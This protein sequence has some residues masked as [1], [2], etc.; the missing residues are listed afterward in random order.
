MNED[1]RMFAAT[2]RGSRRSLSK[3]RSVLRHIA[4]TVLATALVSAASSYAAAADTE[5]QQRVSQLKAP[6]ADEIVFTAVGDMGLKQPLSKSTDPSLQSLFDLLRASDI[7]FMNLEGVMTDKGFPDHK[8][9]SRAHPSIVEDYKWAGTDLVSLGNNHQ[10]DYFETGMERTIATLDAAGIRHAGAG[11]NIAEAFRHTM[12]EKDG[13][14]IALVAALVSPNLT[15][16]TAATETSAGVAQIRGMKIR[17]ADGRSVV[18]PNEDDLAL[19]EASIKEAKK[20][21]P[22]VAVSLHYHWNRDGQVDA[23]GRQLVARAAI[24]AGATMVLGQGPHE[25]NGIEFYKGKLIAY[26]LGNF[27]FQ[28]NAA[29]FE[30]FP[31]VSQM[32]NRFSNDPHMYETFVLRLTLSRAGSTAGQLRRVEILPVEITKE[33]NPHLIANERA[34]QVLDRVGTLSKP[35]GTRVSRQN[36]YSVV[37]LSKSK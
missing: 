12:V 28:L 17:R 29:H 14:K 15:P 33:G 20:A 36:W 35:F 1:L 18:A 34:D 21:A 37:E 13:V 22:I 11:R 10:M 19:L 2:E 31:E 9:I 4:G 32:F 24:D 8:V 16:P 25:I 23:D 30:L 7:F 6:A 5:W 3:S 26:S 27:V